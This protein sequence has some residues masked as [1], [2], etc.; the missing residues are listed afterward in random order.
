MSL[1]TVERRKDFDLV[2]FAEKLPIKLIWELRSSS[3]ELKAIIGPTD[4]LDAIGTAGV[5]RL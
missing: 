3:G 5:I 4:M 1:A 2:N